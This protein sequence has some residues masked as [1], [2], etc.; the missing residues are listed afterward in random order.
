[1]NKINEK[2]PFRDDIFPNSLVSHMFLLRNI[3][4]SSPYA[5]GKMTSFSKEN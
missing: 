3:F 1:M 2:N 4:I 5:V